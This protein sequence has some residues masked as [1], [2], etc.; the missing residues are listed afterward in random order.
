MQCAHEIDVSRPVRSGRVVCSWCRGTIAPA[1]QAEPPGTPPNYGM[2][3]RC[4]SRRL[5][6]LRTSPSRNE[7]P[8][9]AA[10]ARA[11][12]PVARASTLHLQGS[13]R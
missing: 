5:W 8:R 13:S 3:R 10:S 11:A 9:Q 4:L 12:A 2:C 6:L 1:R 7:A